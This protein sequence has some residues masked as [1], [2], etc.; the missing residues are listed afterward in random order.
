MPDKDWGGHCRALLKKATSGIDANSNATRWTLR[1]RRTT[2]RRKFLDG[3]AGLCGTFPWVCAPPFST[4]LEQL[5]GSAADK[6]IATLHILSQKRKAADFGRT[7]I[8]ASFSI[9]DNLNPP[10]F[11][12]PITTFPSTPLSLA[13][14][15]HREL[16]PVLRSQASHFYFFA[17][18]YII[19]R[20]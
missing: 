9:L 12:G 10:G 6:L 2:S 17:G 18:A 4:G 3:F 19:Q 5:V 8:C 13:L 1:P 20:A 16:F 14:E 11:L 7:T 15:V